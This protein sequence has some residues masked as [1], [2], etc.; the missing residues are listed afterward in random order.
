MK[1]SVISLFPEQIRTNLA[2]SITGRALSKGL[3]ELEL[4]QLRDFAINAYGKVDDRLAGG[5]TGMLLRCEPIASALKQIAA[6]TARRLYL[7]PKGRV[8]D[9]T[10]VNELAQET[11]LVLLCGHYEGVDARVLAAEGFEEVSL[12]DYVL[13]GG[14]LGACVL[15]DAVLRQVP[16]VLPSESAYEGE[17]HYAG[18]LE[19]RQYTKP[20]CWE[21]HEIPA[22]LLGGDHAKQEAWKQR[23]AWIETLLKR[24]DLFNQLDLSEQAYVEIA[25]TLAT[26]SPKE[27]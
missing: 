19:Q 2:Q 9:Q 5:G 6:P 17:S 12:G 7:S 25:E 24:P 11:H 21:G 14:E 26:A 27:G 4:I 3:F 15:L 20:A 10:L 18:W 8:L 16:G 22:V 13:T 1:L 23:D